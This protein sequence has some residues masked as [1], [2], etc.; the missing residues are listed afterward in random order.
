MDGKTTYGKRFLIVA[1]E[2]PKQLAVVTL[3][4]ARSPSIPSV[5]EVGNIGLLKPALRS[6]RFGTERP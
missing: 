5:S 2:Q 4:S 6:F 3:T 1:A